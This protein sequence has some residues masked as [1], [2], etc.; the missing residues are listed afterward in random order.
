M[1]FAL[2]TGEFEFSHNFQ[3][4]IFFN[5]LLP[6]RTRVQTRFVTEES[7]HTTYN[8]PAVKSSHGP[9][10]AVEGHRSPGREALSETHK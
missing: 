2:R 6:S 4:S 1:L 8:I 7:A 10:K 9:G 5:L 3:C